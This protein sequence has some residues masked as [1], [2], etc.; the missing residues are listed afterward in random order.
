MSDPDLAEHL[1]KA[2]RTAG[3][4]DPDDGTVPM[5]PNGDVFPSNGT[6]WVSGRRMCEVIINNLPD[7]ATAQARHE[8]I[9][10]AARALVER[11]K[12]APTFVALDV[13]RLFIELEDALGEGTT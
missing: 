10:A 1:R 3:F 12:A 11:R 7:L 13:G 9:E 6:V 2:L 8:R 5:W 4:I